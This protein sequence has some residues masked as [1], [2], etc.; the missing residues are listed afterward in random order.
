MLYRLA[1]GH[2]DADDDGLRSVIDAAIELRR[3][4]CN[5]PP[6]ADW[7]ELPSIARMREKCPGFEEET[8]RQ[9]YYD[10]RIANR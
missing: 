6:E 1:L 7:S 10:F 3:E 8:Y 9:A 2:L 4:A 5:P